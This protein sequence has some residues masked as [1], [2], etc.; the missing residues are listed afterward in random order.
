MPFNEEDRKAFRVMFIVAG[1][2]VAGLLLLFYI[3]VT[4]L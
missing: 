2:F 4:D 1:G 3:I